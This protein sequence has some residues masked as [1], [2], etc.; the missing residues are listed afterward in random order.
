VEVNVMKVTAT[1]KDGVLNVQL[2]KAEATKPAAAGTQ[3]A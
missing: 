1:L 3:A 2:P